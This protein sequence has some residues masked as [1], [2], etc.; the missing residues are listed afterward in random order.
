VSGSHCPVFSLLVP[1]FSHLTERER[2]FPEIICFLHLDYCRCAI[3]RAG[4]PRI[5]AMT[6]LA[7]V[8]NGLKP[9]RRLFTAFRFSHTPYM[10]IPLSSIIQLQACKVL[11]SWRTHNFP[12]LQYRIEQGSELTEFSP[13]LVFN[14]P[15]TEINE[16]EIEVPKNFS[17]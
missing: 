8:S 15:C 14:A 16:I 5:F 2:T 9:D 12:I 10:D 4:M 17:N 13:I 6:S 7:S 1:T 11:E 3:D